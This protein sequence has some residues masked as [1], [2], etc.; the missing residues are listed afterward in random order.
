MYIITINGK[1]T[2]LYTSIEIES[3]LIYYVVQQ[4]YQ[5]QKE[6]NS[7]VRPKVVIDANLIGHPFILQGNGRA[8]AVVVIAKKFANEGIDVTIGP[9]N[10]AVIELI[11]TPFQADPE[12]ARQ[13][14]CSDSDCIISSYSDFP[15]YIGASASTD[16][17]RS[18]KINVNK[19]SFTFKKL[20]T[21]QKNI[22]T[23]INNEVVAHFETILRWYRCF[24]CRCTIQ[25]EES[26]R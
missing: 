25:I 23:W 18:P 9:A 2:I 14:V 7:R 8:K 5:S 3:K 19:S 16:M 12:I 13:M 26:P 4:Q 15:M 22:M 11:V 10:K 1:G 20:V 17:V 6:N 21:G 24:R